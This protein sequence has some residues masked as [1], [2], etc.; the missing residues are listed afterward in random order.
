MC[1]GGNPCL[2]LCLGRVIAQIENGWQPWSAFKMWCGHTIGDLTI[3]HNVRFIAFSC[4]FGSGLG[5]A[6]PDMQHCLAKTGRG[7]GKKV[8]GEATGGK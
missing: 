7:R 1:A 8:G 5:A 3:L 6:Q 4:L 2:A